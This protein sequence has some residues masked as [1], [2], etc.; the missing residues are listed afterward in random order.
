MVSIFEDIASDF[1]P[2][3]VWDK[4]VCSQAYTKL[5]ILFVGL[6]L[7]I[8]QCSDRTITITQHNFQRIGSTD[9]YKNQISTCCKSEHGFWPA[10]FKRKINIRLL[11][12]F[13][14]TLAKNS[15]KL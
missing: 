14:K 7:R 5:G 15:Q 6:I 8:L 13:L 2:M 12:A 9:E 11:L 4:P 1:C 10:L 3:R